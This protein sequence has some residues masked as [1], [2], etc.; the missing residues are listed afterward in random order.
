MPE[1]VI[2]SVI[3]KLQLAHSGS[4][5]PQSAQIPFLSYNITIKLIHFIKNKNN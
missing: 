2:Q 5:L 3:P 4:G 1:H